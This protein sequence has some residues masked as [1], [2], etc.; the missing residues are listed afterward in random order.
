MYQQLQT[1]KQ[2]I[3]SLFTYNV[4][5]IVSDG[6]FARVGTLSSEYSRFMEWKTGDGLTI[7][8]TKR[9][10]ALEPMLKGLLNKRTLLD[11]IRHFIVFEKNHQEG[12]CLSSILCGEQGHRV[13][14]S[15]SLAVSKR[16]SEEF[17]EPS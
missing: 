8:D 13:H 12:G 5:L 14:H 3:P 6:W 2:I 1:Y 9:E 11:L 4:I 16:R 17:F 10:S 15:G 7:V